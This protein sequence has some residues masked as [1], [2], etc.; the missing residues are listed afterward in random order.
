MP[1]RSARAGRQVESEEHLRLGTRH[2]YDS[3]WLAIPAGLRRQFDHNLGEIPWSVSVI[4]SELETGSL[5]REASGDITLV[6][7]DLDGVA[8]SSEQ[9]V[10]V[11]N[12]LAIQNYFRVRAM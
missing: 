2:Q 1:P 8:G 9:S 3:G 6:Y 11:T 4:R 5:P 10:S 12:N 7:A